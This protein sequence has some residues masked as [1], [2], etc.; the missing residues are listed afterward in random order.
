MLTLTS[1][2]VNWGHSLPDG[3]ANSALPGLHAHIDKTYEKNKNID[4]SQEIKNITALFSKSVRLES[5]SADKNFDS[6]LENK[7]LSYQSECVLR[8]EVFNNKAEI[9][10]V[11]FEFKSFAQNYS[12]PWTSV[13]IQVPPSTTQ[14]LFTIEKINPDLEWGQVEYS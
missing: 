3:K 9:V 4:H 8:F 14:H 2:K 12:A 13:I 11:E 6:L 7:N 1:Y 10:R 5:S